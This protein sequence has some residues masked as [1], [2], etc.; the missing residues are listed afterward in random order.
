MKSDTISNLLVNMFAVNPQTCGDSKIK[1]DQCESLS[2]SRVAYSLFYIL[3]L[4]QYH[5]QDRVYI[6][7][8]YF[9]NLIG[10]LL[11]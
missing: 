4:H 1:T 6:V 5:I 10:K 2:S 7:I 3:S 11:V 9:I 8:L